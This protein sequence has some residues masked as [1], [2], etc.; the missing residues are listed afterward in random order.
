M[1]SNVGIVWDPATGPGGERYVKRHPVPFGE[2]IPFR[3][4][5]SPGSVKPAGPDP[6]RLRRRTTGR[7]CSQV[8]P[9]RVGDV[10]CFE[11]AYDGLVRDVVARRRRSCSSCRPTTRP[12]AAPAQPRAAAGDVAAAGGRAR[13]GRPGRRDQRD[14]RGHRARRHGR[15]TAPELVHPDAGRRRCRCATAAPWPTRVG[16]WPEWLLAA[17]RAGCRGVGVRRRRRGGPDRSRRDG[18][19]DPRR[20]ADRRRLRSAVLVVI[21]TYNEA[22]NI[23]RIVDR[24]RAAVPTA[25]VLVVDDNSPDGTGDDR[26]PARRG[27]RPRCTCCTGRPRRVSAPPTSPASAG[28]SS[29]ATTCSSRWTPTGRTSPSSC[30]GCSAALADADLVLGSRWVPGGAVVNWPLHRRAAL[31]RAATPTSGS[32]SGS[33]SA[34]PPAAS[35]RSAA[36]TLE[37]LDLDGVAVAGLLLP[38]RPG[39]A[40]GPSRATGSSRC[41]SRSSSG[42]GALAR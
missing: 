33:G 26:R 19:D 31:P 14:Q 9:A 21:P 2:Y 10:I 40:R 17:R 6:A 29:A 28:G 24:V 42:A 5:R 12:T 39:P 15:G 4:D 38:G 1:C 32:R 16:A 13:P 18:R 36:A 41:R 25:D 22:D 7:A 3:A 23:E 20:A 11:V 8:G 37:G 27:R 30:R 35:A 34:T